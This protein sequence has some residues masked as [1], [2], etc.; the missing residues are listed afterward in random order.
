MK[1]KIGDRVRIISGRNKGIIG[2][3]AITNR[4]DFYPYGINLEKKA[5]RDFGNRAVWVKKKG[6]SDIANECG[7]ELIKEISAIDNLKRKL[8]L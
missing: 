8:D 4:N 6:Y 7:I 1:Y 2:I 5:I 3:I